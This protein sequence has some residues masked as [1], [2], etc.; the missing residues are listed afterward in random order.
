MALSTGPN[1]G[2]L[3]NGIKGEEHYDLLMRMWR[4][5]DSIVQPTVKGRLSVAP[6]SPADGDTYIIIPTATGTWSGHDNKIGRYSS[7]LATWE[8]FTPK[9]GWTFYDQLAGTEYRYNGTNWAAVASGGG[10]GSGGGLSS[11]LTI[12]TDTELTLDDANSIVIVDASAGETEL[13]IPGN[14]FVAFDVPTQFTV[15]NDT[16]SPLR[17]IFN[18]FDCRIVGDTTYPAFRLAAGKKADI[19]KIDSEAWITGPNDVEGYYPTDS[20]WRGRRFRFTGFTVAGTSMKLSE[21]QLFDDAA[22]RISAD[23]AVSATEATAAGVME[24]LNNNDLTDG[25]EFDAADAEDP[26]FYINYVFAT[27]HTLSGIKLGGVDGADDYPTTLIGEVWIDGVGWTECMNITGLIYPG[28]ETLSALIPVTAASAIEG[29]VMYLDTAN[30]LSYD[31]SSQTWHNLVTVPAEGVENDWDFYLGSTSGAESTDPAFSGTPGTD[32]C[33]FALGSTRR[34]TL[35]AGTSPTSTFL[36]HL[37]YAAK[38][39]TVEIWFKYKGEGVQSRLLDTGTQDFGGSYTSRGVAVGEFG[40]GHKIIHRI[41]RDSSGAES[42]TVV[43]DNAF[44]VNS[45]YMI[46]WSQDGT[47]ADDS[48]IYRNGAYDPV[49]SANTWDGTPSSP[50]TNPANLSPKIGIRGDGGYGGVATDTEIYMIRVYNRNLSKSE[51]D[52]NWAYDK[53]RFGL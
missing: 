7:I 9:N 30:T 6:G 23:A 43:S 40:G 14:D 44:T 39:F 3:V 26:A 11:A 13:V 10:G 45:R 46:A 49:G 51:L 47:G 31:G 42:K 20:I 38:K 41:M 4:A 34:L 25:V 36:K 32:V 16:A 37:H 12:V 53:A 19:Y 48:F 50:G 1:L 29:L 18:D 21:L 17:V 35:A 2:L 52:L 28:D 22:A 5:L 33:Y 27:K 24:D 8:Y 15:Y